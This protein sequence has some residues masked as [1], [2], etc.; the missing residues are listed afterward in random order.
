[1][2]NR[3]HEKGRELVNDFFELIKK[4][5]LDYKSY[6]KSYLED[7]KE[8]CLRYQL[9]R[10]DLRIERLNSIKK[11]Y[12][13]FRPNSPIQTANFSKVN[14]IYIDKQT[15]HIED[16]LDIVRE[17]RMRIREKLE[18]FIVKRAINEMREL[19]NEN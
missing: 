8:G 17:E 9:H 6:Y 11:R 19:R 10:K 16:K 15:I 7:I 18:P 14:G 5:Y 3:L 13:H 2:L 1:M 12:D 4:E